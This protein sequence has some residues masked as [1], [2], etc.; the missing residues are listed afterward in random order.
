VLG[1]DTST[2]NGYFI[3][4]A[5]SRVITRFNI[6][7]N[8]DVFP[9]QVEKEA[10][11]RSVSGFD[12]AH[13][14]GPEAVVSTSGRVS[15]KMKAS[16]SSPLHLGS[17][18]TLEESKS[19]DVPEFVDDHKHCDVVSSSNVPNIDIESNTTDDDM[20]D[21]HLRA[22]DDH[23]DDDI[24]DVQSENATL[25]T[26]LGTVEEKD[27][28]VS[29]SHI[30]PGILQEQGDMSDEFE[31]QPEPEEWLRSHSLYAPPLPTTPPP[32]VVEDGDDD[33]AAPYFLQDDRRYQAYVSV[34][35]SH[36][37]PTWAQALAS[38]ESK[39][40]Q[41]GA[42]RELDS[43]FENDAITFVDKVDHEGKSVLPAMIICKKKRN[44]LNEVVL[45][46]CRMVAGGHKQIEGVHY[47]PSEL[48]APTA[49]QLTIKLVFDAIVQLELA[50][51][52]YDVITAFL[53]SKLHKDHPYI[54]I[55]PPQGFHELMVLS[56]RS[57]P[58]KGTYYI[59]VLSCIYGLKQASF[60]WNNKLTAALISFGWVQGVV[61]KCLFLKF[62][63]STPPKIIGYLVLFVDDLTVGASPVVLDELEKQLAAAF[64]MKFLGLPS[65]FTGISIKKLPGGAL[66]LHQAPYVNRMV[67]LWGFGNA[68]VS[69]APTTT[70]RLSE[71]PATQE[72]KQL[73]RDKPY[74]SLVGVCLWLNITCRKDLG[75]AVHR[76][77]LAPKG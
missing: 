74:R 6:I 29:Q 65:T 23:S 28:V 24:Y 58:P 62:D 13:M 47:D 9:G 33:E 41:E 40:W 38:P 69:K 61:D 7:P 30:P 25:G 21:V 45:Y 48:Y 77:R 60:Y 18:R 31:F 42:V 15:S 51:R 20:S 22:S 2:P 32:V 59:R 37:E 50:A 73:M 34:L 11:Q 46:K 19:D 8:S 10:V 53:L 44:D 76:K 55:N 64:P 67:A 63:E 35:K 75:F 54:L 12:V 43:L 3:L 17:Q 49:A 39:S 27:S 1:Y 70:E 68:S 52:Q 14:L 5:N 36:D 71:V 56:G 57:V 72:E 66:K 26:S 16:K 4:R